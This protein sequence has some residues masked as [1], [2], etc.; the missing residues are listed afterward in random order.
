[1]KTKNGERVPALLALLLCLPGA[2]WAL[3]SDRDKPMHIEADNVELDDQSGVSVYRGDVVITQGTMRITGDQVTVYT[4]PDA[5]LKRAVSVGQPATYKQRPDDKPE[6][7]KARALA[8]EYFADKDTVVLT[9]EARLWQG[10]NT[11][12]SKKIIYDVANDRVDAGKQSGGDR[13]RITIHPEK[14]DGAGSPEKPKSP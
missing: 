13:V 6:D 12:V 7:V 2:A 8:M 4:T 11:F 1:M 9:D 5:K 10:P 14:R 3:K